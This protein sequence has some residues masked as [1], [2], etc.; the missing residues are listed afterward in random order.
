MVYKDCLVQW[1]ETNTLPI[2]YQGIKHQQTNESFDS[3]YDLSATIGGTI[4]GH[5]LTCDRLSD[6]LGI[7]TRADS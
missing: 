2:I 1:P 5:L 4:V 6:S 7:G 3:V